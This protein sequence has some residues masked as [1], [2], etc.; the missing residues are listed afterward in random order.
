M[1]KKDT[2]KIGELTKAIEKL[3]A[4]EIAPVLPVAPVLPIAPIAPL[5]P[6]NPEDHNLIL[7][8]VG[9]MDTVN[10]KVDALKEDI[11]ELKKDKEIF[12]TTKE[13]GEVHFAVSERLKKLEDIS[14]SLVSFKDTL[15]GK[16]VMMGGMSGVIVGIIMIIIK[17]LINKM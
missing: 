16:M 5:L 17:Y 2:D 3:I 1:V 10:V 14:I 13:H 9:K 11:A 7:G 15:T 8:L 6:S 4:R 12:V